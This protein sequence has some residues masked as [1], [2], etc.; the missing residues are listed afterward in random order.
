MVVS[1]ENIKVWDETIESLAK[2]RSRIIGVDYD[3]LIQEG[4]VAVLLALLGDFEPCE[5]DI[6]NAMRR[7]IRNQKKCQTTTYEIRNI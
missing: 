1:D 3:D 5:L 2:K 7:Y 4:R 6:K